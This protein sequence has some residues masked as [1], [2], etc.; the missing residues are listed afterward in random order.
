VRVSVRTSGADRLPP[1]VAATVHRAAREALRNVRSHSDATGVEVTVR[2][3]RDRA[4]VVVE[5]DGRGFDAT[6][7]AQRAVGGH[8]GLRAL[9]DLLAAAGGTLTAASAPGEGTRLTVE[10]PLD[11]SPVGVH[12]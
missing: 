1:P 8:L 7:L 9:G 11:R 2:C 12:R 5:D 10:V 3:E 6:R 4:T